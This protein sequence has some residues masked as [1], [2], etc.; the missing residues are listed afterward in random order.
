MAK[1]VSIIIRLQDKTKAGIASAR[2][3]FSKFTSE[4]KSKLKSLND[5]LGGLGTTIAGA[6]SVRAVMGFGRELLTTAANL[7]AVSDRA[8]ITAVEMQTFLAST[9]RGG[10][11]ISEL[12]IGLVTLRK[13]QQNAINGMPEAVKAFNALGLSIE[14]VAN[15]TNSQLLEAVAKGI[16]RTG[17]FGNGF[18]LMGESTARLHQLISDLAD[19][20]VDGLTDKMQSLGQVM[21]NETVKGLEQANNS[22]VEFNNSLTVIAGSTA[23]FFQRNIE[24]TLAVLMTLPSGI[25][26]TKELLDQYDREGEGGEKADTGAQDRIAEQAKVEADLRA[27]AKAEADKKA[28]EKYDQETEQIMKAAEKRSKELAG[29][30]TDE[31][32]KAIEDD[33][34]REIAEIGRALQE[35]LG[36]LQG[37]SDEENALRLQLAA[38]AKAEIEK[39][40][41]D[42]HDAEQEKADALAD[43]A[44]EQEQ[45]RQSKLAD[46]QKTALQSRL[47]KVNEALADLDKSPEQRKAEDREANALRRVREKLSSG[48]QRFKDLSEKDKDTFNRGKLN[49]IKAKT[50]ADLAK[51]EKD[52]FE[53]M[54]RVANVIAPAGGN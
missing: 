1:D 10:G 45:D 19:N 13:Q 32:I 7:Q 5:S 20:G 9:K 39:V 25:K 46:A 33:T 23:G 6:F 30:L 34:A 4:T 31:K 41:Q 3:G 16:K 24:K 8:G 22:L 43:E 18:K 12:N 11:T 21:S 54:V 29:A 27:S 14:D 49:A 51:T 2:S 37:G 48:R 38:N 50:E 47:G 42:K 36:A 53:A 52:G 44:K 40:L 17:D 15:M 28:Q 35:K 26:A